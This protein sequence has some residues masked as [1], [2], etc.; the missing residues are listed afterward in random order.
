MK[1]L[2]GFLSQLLLM[3]NS[4]MVLP[5]AFQHISESYEAYPERHRSRFM[6]DICRIQRQSEQTGESAVRIFYQFSQTSGNRELARVA[7]MMASSLNTGTD[8]WDG[9]EEECQAMWEN[10]KRQVLEKIRVGESKMSFPLGL[11]MAALLLV[12][13]APAMLQI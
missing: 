13:A 6:K 2:P 8:L 5:A 3:L 7:G 11:L 12:T 4:G 1:D 9:L 10:R